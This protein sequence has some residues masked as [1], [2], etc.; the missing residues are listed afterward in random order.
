[1]KLKTKLSTGLVFLFLI[2]FSLVFL[3]IFYIDKL[4]KDSDNILKD[5]FNSLKYTEK[6]ST[7]LDMLFASY[8]NNNSD[9]KSDKGF[10][11][12]AWQDSLKSTFAKYLALEMRNITEKGEKEKVE[13][14]ISNFDILQKMAE[15]DKL[16]KHSEQELI[17]QFV[18]TKKTISS[19]TELN[20]KAINSKNQISVVDYRN[21]KI[22]IAI[23]GSFCII[24]AFAYFWYFPFY[25]SYTNALL[26][27]RMK[28]MLSSKGINIDYQ[29]NDENYILLESINFLKDKTLIINIEGKEK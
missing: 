14:L 15:D 5:N 25:V 29:S 10:A 18:L 6:M 2:I 17:A 24:L 7:N 3:E 23:V 27:E 22:K 13:E 12:K 9:S 1:M 20:I 16:I 26:S 11:Q 4:A 21:I 8:F 28:A 19:V